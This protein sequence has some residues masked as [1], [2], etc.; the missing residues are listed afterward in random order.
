[1]RFWSALSVCAAAAAILMTGVVLSAGSPEDPAGGEPPRGPGDS[2]KEDP[3]QPAPKP[4]RPGLDAFKVPGIPPDQYGK[5][6]GNPGTMVAVGK[7]FDAIQRD[8]VEAGNG[9]A[10]PFL[11][12]GRKTIEKLADLNELFRKIR[13]E[14][15]EKEKKPNT[16]AVDLRVVPNG[17]T[18]EQAAAW[19]WGEGASFGEWQQKLFDHAKGSEADL[20]E[21][22]LVRKTTKQAAD[23]KSEIQV[24]EIV[25]KGDSM[26][27][28][29]KDPDSVDK[30]R[31][32]GFVD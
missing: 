28:A 20:I 19:L 24:P 18:A 6:V 13:A 15:L 26:L 11:L 31:V 22:F 16:M 17:A 8:G 14:K 3:P 7:F 29:V 1:M 27:I 10:V 23:S 25:N 9:A 5:L 4:V 30:A 12:D 2:K 32:I 21:V